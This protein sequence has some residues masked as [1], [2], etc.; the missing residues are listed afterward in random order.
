MPIAEFYADCRVLC[1]L[2]G[3]MLSSNFARP[4]KIN[5]ELYAYCRV[6]CRLQVLCY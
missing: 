4:Q 6:L 2:P 3:F 1:R 5:A